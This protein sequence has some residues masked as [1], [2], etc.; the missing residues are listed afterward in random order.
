MAEINL[1]T[2]EMLL[3]VVTI[4]AITILVSVLTKDVRK[5][6]TND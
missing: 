6:D 4:A 5:N 3:A 2:I 1:F